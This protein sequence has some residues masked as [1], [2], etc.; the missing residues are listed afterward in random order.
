M[1][2]SRARKRESRY[3]RSTPCLER[4]VEKNFRVGNLLNSFITGICAC[5]SVC[6]C[7]TDVHRHKLIFKGR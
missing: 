6:V 3:K 2:E 1:V 5:V 7:D 4:E